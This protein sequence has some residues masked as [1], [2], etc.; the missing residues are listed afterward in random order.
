M[1]L[2]ECNLIHLWVARTQ[3]FCDMCGGWI[4]WVGGTRP[5]L[6]ISTQWDRSPHPP[7]QKRG[8]LISKL[9]QQDLLKCFIR[10][11]GSWRVVGKYNICPILTQNGGRVKWPNIHVLERYREYYSPPPGFNHITVNMFLF[12][13]LSKNRTWRGIY[14]QIC[15]KCNKWILF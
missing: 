10:S 14:Y 2:K 5:Q 6:K 1:G 12:V 3:I 15:H 9:G 8:L 4:L 7:P 13:Y 11:L